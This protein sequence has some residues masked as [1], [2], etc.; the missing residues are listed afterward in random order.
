[1]KDSVLILKYGYGKDNIFLKSNLFYNLDKEIFLYIPMYIFKYCENIIKNH[2]NKINFFV[3]PCSYLWLNNSFK[4][5]SNNKKESINRIF[6]AENENINIDEKIKKLENYEYLINIIDKTINVQNKMFNIK[7]YSLNDIEQEILD[8]IKIEKNTIN[9]IIPPSFAIID[10]EINDK[11]KRILKINKKILEI[12]YKDKKYEHNFLHIICL[13]PK[14]ILNDCFFELFLKENIIIKDKNVL[15]W[16]D[17]FSLLKYRKKEIE[18]IINFF[19]FFESKNK[20]LLHSDFPTSLLLSKHL[21]KNNFSHIITNIG[22]GEKRKIFEDGGRAKI[23][24]YL[25][26]LHKRLQSGEF[27]EYLKNLKIIDE[28]NGIII[29]EKFIKKICNC[30]YCQE[31]LQTENNIYKIIYLLERKKDFLNN[32]ERQKKELIRKLFLEHFLYSKINEYEIINKF[33]KNDLIMYLKN[34][35]SEILE[36]KEKNFFKEILYLLNENKK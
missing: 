9:Y 16:L 23:Y 22:Y 8:F 12:I 19:N 3:D 28:K 34:V 10:N 24:Y 7:N 25:P 6:G 11:V 27:E 5:K 33:N 36:K 20:I 35:E 1:M 4:N 31:I 32:K 13:N 2:S 21:L 26:K 30:Q 17:D 29:R 18:K 15:F 14:L